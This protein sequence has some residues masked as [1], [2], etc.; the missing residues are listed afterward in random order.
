MTPSLQELSILIYPIHP[1]VKITAEDYQIRKFDDHYHQLPI[2]PP[3]GLE[4]QPT[5]DFDFYKPSERDFSHY[6][7]F[8]QRLSVLRPELADAIWESVRMKIREIVSAGTDW[9]YT[10]RSTTP[11]FIPEENLQKI[12][13]IHPEFPPNH[14][15]TFNI[16]KVPNEYQEI[17]NWIELWQQLG[18]KLTAWILK[19]KENCSLYGVTSWKWSHTVRAEVDDR[20]FSEHFHIT[21]DNEDKELDPSGDS[22]EQFNWWTS[23]S[24]NSHCF[25]VH[26]EGSRKRKFSPEIEESL[27]DSSEHTLI[28]GNHLLNESTKDYQ[29]V[30]W[31]PS[32][33][34]QFENQWQLGYPAYMP[35]N[36]LFNQPFESSGANV[37]TFGYFHSKGLKPL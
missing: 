31:K 9:E 22:S 20:D 23:P 29:L 2:K 33:R 7:I 27:P 11:E 13:M 12:H 17:L 36:S 3:V 16:M 4:Y 14:C 1:T 15:L 18:R 6:N 8:N 32:I 30:E 35:T 19:A 5:N 26:V 28:I 37:G 21:Y 34:E 10:S 24:I 25:G